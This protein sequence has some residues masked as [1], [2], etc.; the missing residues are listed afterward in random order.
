V[1]SEYNDLNTEA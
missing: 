1:N